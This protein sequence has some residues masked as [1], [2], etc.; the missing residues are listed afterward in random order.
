MRWPAKILLGTI[1][2][3]QRSFSAIMGRQCRYYPT[4]S[5]YTAEAIRRFGAL[6][7]TAL[8]VHRICRCH[9]WGG[10]G[11]DM[12]PDEFRLKFFSKKTACCDRNLG[13]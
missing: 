1:W 6:K 2:L 12:V 9:P 5:S 13:T 7:G 8:G 10:S 4:C 11:V 3:Y